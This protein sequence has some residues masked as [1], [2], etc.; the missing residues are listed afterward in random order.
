M[1][2]GALA[3]MG[4][5]WQRTGEIDAWFRVQ[6]EAWGE[7]TDFGGESFIELRSFFRNPLGS[8]DVLI[9]GID[10]DPD[11]GA[12]RAPAPRRGSR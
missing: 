10:D 5:L 7:R 11:R 2:L 8:G 4:Y 1:P 6:T 12:R 9:I 3:F